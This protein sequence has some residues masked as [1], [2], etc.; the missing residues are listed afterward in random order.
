LSDFLLMRGEELE[1][2]M[3][4]TR[5]AGTAL[6]DNVYQPPELFLHG[7]A[8]AASDLYMVAASLYEALTG[9]PPFAATL[10]LP[11]LMRAIEHDLPRPPRD[12]NRS[13]PATVEAALLRALAKKPTE[14]FQ[15]AAGFLRALTNSP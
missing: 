6:R 1:T 2:A 15:S 5:G 11:A 4:I 13:L 10:E 14:R 3:E 12:Y 7:E 8:T 9:H